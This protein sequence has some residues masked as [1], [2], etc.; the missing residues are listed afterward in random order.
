[1]IVQGSAKTKTEVGQMEITE[2]G[3]SINTKSTMHVDGMKIGTRRW[4]ES[5]LLIILYLV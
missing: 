2:I 4:G 5:Y 1:L 3:L